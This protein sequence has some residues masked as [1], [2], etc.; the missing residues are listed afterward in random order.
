MVLRSYSKIF[1]KTE[2]GNDKMTVIADKE[3]SRLD[4]PMDDSSLMQSSE[5]NQLSSKI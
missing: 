4:V 5:S 2:V 1:S 3:I